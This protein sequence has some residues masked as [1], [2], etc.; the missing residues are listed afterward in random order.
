VSTMKDPHATDSPQSRTTRMA[1][2]L[3]DQLGAH[4]EHLD[5]DQVI[6]M[7]H[8]ADQQGGVAYDGYGTSSEAGEDMI[9]FIQAYFEARGSSFRVVHMNAP[10]NRPGTS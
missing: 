7:I 3:A 9:S 5:G 4:H 8:G 6:V 2:W 10:P 1:A